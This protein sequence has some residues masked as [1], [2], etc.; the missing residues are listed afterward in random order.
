MSGRLEG[1]VA[2][3]TGAARGIGR[4][5]AERLASEGAAVAIADLDHAGAKG[6]AATIEAGGGRAIAHETDVAVESS[7]EALLR[8]THEALGPVDILHSNAAD[9]SLATLGSDGDLLSTDLA[10][11]DR[12]LA[13]NLRGAV[14]CC[15][16]VLPQMLERERGV[17]VIT[18]STSGLTG[19]L[20]RIAYGASK[21]AL[22]SLTQNIATLY[23]KRGIRC[24][25]VA[26]GLIVTEGSPDV[27][28]RD[29][30][31]PPDD[32]LAFALS[33]H[34]TP[35]LGLPTDVAALVAFLAS[36]EAA[37]ITGQIIP[38]DGGLLSHMPL[39]GQQY[40]STIGRT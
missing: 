34:L 23:G 3:V 22:N 16:A 11:W 29:S 4:A 40:A 14:L 28:S 30:D 7:V 38:I 13:V 2:I 15:R 8:A 39:F 9:T 31:L 25:A 26:P 21:A 32:A 20:G 17:L 19:D 1:R 33:H 18:S 6:V 10:I 35:R 24:N 36:D 12:T 27:S 5:C 37:Y